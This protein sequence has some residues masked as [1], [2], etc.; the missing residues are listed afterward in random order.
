MAF[1]RQPNLTEGEPELMPHTTVDGW[2]SGQNV[3]RFLQSLSGYIG[4]RYDAADEDALTGAL[5]D[6]D[7]ESATAWFRYPL[8]GTPPVMVSLAQASGGSVVSVR[9]EGELDSILQARIDTM[10]DLL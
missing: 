5:D 2:V 9:V 3:V 4:Y 6:T 8:E 1:G 7:D 10:L